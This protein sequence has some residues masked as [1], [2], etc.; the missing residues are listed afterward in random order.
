MGIFASLAAITFFGISLPLFVLGVITFILLSVVSYTEDFFSGMTAWAVILIVL[1][2]FAGNEPFSW[3]AIFSLETFF[4]V[5]SWFVFGAAW[6][7]FKWMMLSKKKKEEFEVAL[8]KETKYNNE[9][10]THEEKKKLASKYIPLVKNH[11]ER[12]FTWIL[13]WPLSIISY[14]LGDLVR[15]LLEWIVKRLGNV[16][17]LITKKYFGDLMDDPVGEK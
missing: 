2:F 6:F 1:M 8:E 16:C 4:E 5:A 11:K 3:H 10:L 13:L 9:P 17:R 12:I 14:V 7:L 15:D